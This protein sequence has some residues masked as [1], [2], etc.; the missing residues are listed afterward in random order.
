MKLRFIKSPVNIQEE[1]ELNEIITNDSKGF[2]IKL[3][4]NIVEVITP[5]IKAAGLACEAMHDAK[6][7]IIKPSV[8]SLCKISFTCNE[9]NTAYNITAFLKDTQEVSAGEF[10]EYLSNIPVEAFDDLTTGAG[11][12]AITAAVLLAT[13][14]LL[15]PSAA[16]L[17]EALNEAGMLDKVKSKLSALGSKIANG[18]GSI[19]DKANVAGANSAEKKMTNARVK[20]LVDAV[21]KTLTEELQKL[22]NKGDVKVVFDTKGLSFTVYADCSYVAQIY[23]GVPTSDTHAETINI[24]TIKTPFGDIALKNNKL[25]DNLNRI[26]KVLGF[27]VKLPDALTKK[28][29]GTDEPKEEIPDTEEGRLRASLGDE[30]TSLIDGTSDES[31]DESYNYNTKNII[32]EKFTYPAGLNITGFDD[33]LKKVAANKAEDLVKLFLIKALD[34]DKLFSEKHIS[35][36][37]VSDLTYLFRKAGTFKLGANPLADI[38]LMYAAK[39]SGDIYSSLLNVLTELDNTVLRDSKWRDDENN[40]IYNPKFFDNNKMTASELADILYLYYMCNNGKYYKYIFKAS[41]KDLEEVIKAAKN[42]LDDDAISEDGS[43]LLHKVFFENF[44]NLKFR[45]LNTIKEIIQQIKAN[46]DGASTADNDDEESI[47]SNSRSTTSFKDAIKKAEENPDD[48][49]L[50]KVLRTAKT[51]DFRDLTSA[52]KRNI[53]TVLKSIFP[54]EPSST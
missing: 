53:L 52:Q 47:S 8:K 24:S 25:V 15:T 13:A 51:S 26:G 37:T 45:N 49:D 17:E 28:S 44:D 36:K 32:V 16:G 30:I 10:A 43:D 18:I 50:A 3:I 7:I 40:I 9:D 46:S 20:T 1:T 21:S 54:E 5:N 31:A 41:G 22:G 42:A 39:N 38:A 34:N 27:N 6:G 19:K 12:D 23:F 33:A 48:V 29:G 4:N 2:R 35:G 14:G 11:A